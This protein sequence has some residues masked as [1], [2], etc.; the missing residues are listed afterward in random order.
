MDCTRIYLT[1]I[2]FTKIYCI[3]LYEPCLI[4][5][6]TYV[7]GTCDAYKSTSSASNFIFTV[8]MM[9]NEI[10]DKTSVF[11]KQVLATCLLHLKH[12]YRGDAIAQYSTKV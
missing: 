5:T 3:G 9:D 2:P 4:F 6:V 8:V 10:V 11:S 12:K 1:Y 7:Y